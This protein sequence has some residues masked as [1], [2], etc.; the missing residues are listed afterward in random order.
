MNPF[1]KDVLGLVL[2]VT[3]VPVWIFVLWVMMS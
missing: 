3:Q 2:I 1:W